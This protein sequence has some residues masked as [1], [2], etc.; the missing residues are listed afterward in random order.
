[1]STATLMGT[2]TADA[3]AIT[4]GTMTGVTS[5]GGITNS[6]VRCSA[7]VTKNANT[8][9]ADVT[10][11]SF[12]NIVAGTYRFVAA[13]PST[14]AAGAGGVKYC[15]NYSAGMVVGTLGSTALGYT[16]SAVAVQ[17]VVTTTTQTDLFTQAAV[18]ISVLITGTMV[19]TTG[20]TI[21]VQF[22]QN[23]SDVSN[24]VAKA[25]GWF[26]MNRIA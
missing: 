9:Y 22:A 14:V 23:T 25:G 8:T 24:S 20:G 2:Q 6:I 19:V 5:T 1:M 13:L 17:N 10:G 12:T 15:F 4:G 11:L 18:V 16:A 3:V 26:Q 21:S 7:D